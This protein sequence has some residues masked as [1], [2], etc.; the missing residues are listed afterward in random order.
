MFTG[1]VTEV[2]QVLALEVFSDRR[3]LR[4]A[5][6]RAEHPI[7]VGASIAVAGVC[8][9]AVEIDEGNRTSVV[10]DIGAETLAVTNAAH[11]K[12][13][14][15]LN[16]ERALR[17]GD[18]LGGHIVSG[19]VDGLATILDMRNFNEMTHV[20]LSAPADLA[21][22]VAKKGSVALDGVSLTVNAVDGGDFEVLLIPHT[23]DVTTW[24][25]RKVGDAMNFEVDTMAR[26]AARLI[27][28]PSAADKTSD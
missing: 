19:H 20:R 1:I 25:E 24:R 28:F 15:G 18:E 2:A 21:K 13:G 11:W 10:F 14:D 17:V 6:K 5:L 26:Y 22:F 23:I 4:L 16:V 9:T 8:L 27:G 12:V 7:I 3:R